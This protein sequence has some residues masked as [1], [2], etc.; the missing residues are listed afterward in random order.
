MSHRFTYATLALPLVAAIG[1]SACKKQEESVPAPTP[2]SEELDLRSRAQALLGVIEV[3]EHDEA[4]AALGQKL[5]HDPNLSGD[6][7]ISCASCHVVS[8]GGDDGLPT[9]PGIGGA[10]GPINSP[11]SLNSHLNFVQFWDGRAET[12]EEQA[13]GP[14][15][16]PLEMGSS[17]D[18]VLEYLRSEP[19]YV[20]GFEA[21]FDGQSGTSITSENLAIAIADY[22]RS[23]ATTGSDF[24][25]WLEGDDAAMSD[26]A[27]AGL[28]AFMDVGCTTCHMGPGL[29]G[30][31]FQKMGL[32]HDWFADQDRALTDADMGRMAATGN[33]AHRHQFKVPLLRN[34]TATAPYFHDGS[35]EDLGE[36]VR[37][38]AHYQLGK[39]LTEDE[40]ASIVAFLQALDGE[41]P[42][43]VD[44]AALDLPA[45]RAGA[46][47][48][49]AP[50]EASGSEPAVVE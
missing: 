3:P 6:G 10:V 22:E 49:P 34:V 2:Q 47:A 48:P 15:E 39:T 42:A 36:A 41:L 33:E 9:S 31:M 19:T 14:I 29:G 46:A 4:R 12:L 25:R 8:E 16:N 17:L 7:T 18:A 26:Q 38:M 35:V 44:V 27:V 20:A 37:Q 13:L 21:A 11:T 5:Y 50:V 32:V 28:R 1:L 43:P 30:T 40:I 45:P 24:D 23:L